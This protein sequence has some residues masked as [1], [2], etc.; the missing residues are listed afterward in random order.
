MTPKQI[1]GD[2]PES[3][4]AGE[5]EEGNVNSDEKEDDSETKDTD[6]DDV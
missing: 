3:E 4:K 5:N 6:S 1:I 2:V